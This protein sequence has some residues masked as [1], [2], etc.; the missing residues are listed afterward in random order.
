MISLSKMIDEVKGLLQSWSLDEEQSTTLTATMGSADLTFLVTAG[1]GVATGASPGIMEIGQELMYC[2]TVAPDGTVTVTAWGRGYLNTTAA[3]H[4]VGSRVISQ[5]SFPRAKVLDAINQ[6]MYRVFPAVF[7]VKSVEQVTTVPSITYTMP[8]DC[9]RVLNVR[10]QQPDGRNYWQGVRRW[11]QWPGGGTLTGDTGITVDVSDAMMPGRPIQ[12]IYA[13]K[14]AALVNET[15]DFVTVTGL[16]IGIEDVI[17]TG[18]AAQMLKSQ[19]LSRLQMSTVEQQNRAQL[20]APSAALTASRALEQ[21]F[22]QRL[23]EERKALQQLYPPRITGSW[24]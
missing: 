8:S 11:R 17:T 20:V 2:D 12:F 14:P 15:D 13:A 23:M 4:L 3:N 10:W 21:T 18:A 19:E 24:I 5:P 16:D 22:Q 6:T 9:E 7:A 1:K